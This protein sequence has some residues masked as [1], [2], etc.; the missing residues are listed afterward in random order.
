MSKRSKGHDIKISTSKRLAIL[1]IT[2]RDILRIT[3]IVPSYL[4]H[5]TSYRH[6]LRI[7]HRVTHPSVFFAAL[8][9]DPSCAIRD[10]QFVTFESWQPTL[11]KL[12]AFIVR[13]L[14][15]FQITLYI[16]HYKHGRVRSKDRAPFVTETLGPRLR[17]TSRPRLWK[18]M[19]FIVPDLQYY[20]F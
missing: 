7:T 16:V 13:H 17:D 3:Q 4:A 9:R 5:H 11:L 1:G 2:H 20:F 10:L 14:L 19:A 18:L 12:M 6:I 15:L 8:D